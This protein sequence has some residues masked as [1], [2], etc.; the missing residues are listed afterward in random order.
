MD[1][2]EQAEMWN[3]TNSVL[4]R[5]FGGW[6]SDCQ[7]AQGFPQTWLRSY[8]LKRDVSIEFRD[9]DE[10]RCYTVFHNRL[11]LIEVCPDS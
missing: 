8:E 3:R 1:A 7:Q 10:T 2:Q 6:L 11:P 4:G 9:G 5:H